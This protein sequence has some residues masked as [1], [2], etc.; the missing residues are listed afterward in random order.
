ML[1]MA[2]GRVLLLWNAWVPS[3]VVMVVFFGET[4][5]DGL[6][7]VGVMLSCVVFGVD[8]SEGGPENVDGPFSRLFPGSV[9]NPIGPRSR[10]VGDPNGPDHV[11]F[12]WRPVLWVGFA[13]RAVLVGCLEPLFGVLVVG[14]FVVECAGPV[15]V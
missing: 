10:C 11:F 13:R 15:V 1:E 4:D 6:V 14:V 7:E 5:K 9:R 12:Q 2:R 8:G 3:V